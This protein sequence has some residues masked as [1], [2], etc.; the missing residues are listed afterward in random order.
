MKAPDFPQTHHHRALALE[1]PFLTAPVA[2]AAIYL[3]Y[4][5]KV[6]LYVQICIGLCIGQPYLESGGLGPV[7]ECLHAGLPQLVLTCSAIS[8][9]E[10]EVCASDQKW[11]LLP[12]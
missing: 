5:G 2:G 10:H 1:R 8:P 6:E 12:V 9:F 7:H 11:Q 4:L 3:C